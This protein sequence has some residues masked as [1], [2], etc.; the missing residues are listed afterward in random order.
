MSEQMKAW[1]AALVRELTDW[2]NVTPK[3]FFGFTALYRGKFMFGL[4]P[5]TRNIFNPNS[6]AFRIE[7]PNRATK[8]LI[9]NDPRISVFDKHR[10]R[11]F[12][13]ELSPNSDLHDALEYLGRAFDAARNSRKPK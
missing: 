12:S 6:V 5:R 4:V 11:W 8:S 10:T 9:D 2:P 13:F 1:S 7:G 3:T